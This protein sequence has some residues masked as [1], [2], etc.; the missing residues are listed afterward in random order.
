MGIHIAMPR[1]PMVLSLVGNVVRTAIHPPSCHIQ[2][3]HR[4]IYRRLPYLHANQVPFLIPPHQ[5][6]RRHGH[7]QPTSHG[8][9]PTPSPALLGPNIV[10]CPAVMCWS[11]VFRLSQSYTSPAPVKRSHQLYSLPDLGSTGEWLLVWLHEQV[12][13]WHLPFVLQHVYLQRLVRVT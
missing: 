9:S 5:T 11:F 7:L 8:V 12:P 3:T 10:W 1:Q 13:P 6:A 2:I 4:H